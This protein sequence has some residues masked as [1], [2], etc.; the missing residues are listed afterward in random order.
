MTATN[1]QQVV[2]RT[3]HGYVEYTE[4][5]HRGVRQVTV[6]LQ[7][8]DIRVLA[9]YKEGPLAS[10]TSLFVSEIETFVRDAKVAL[11]SGQSAFATRC[12]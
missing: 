5:K 4:P 1:L 8:D 6:Y 3:G 11:S 10:P 12:I 2:F 7:G 9:L